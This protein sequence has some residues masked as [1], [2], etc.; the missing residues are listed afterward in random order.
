M[1]HGE[2]DASITAPRRPARSANCTMSADARGDPIGYVFYFVNSVVDSYCIANML[3]DGEV[4]KIIA[5]KCGLLGS[6]A[7]F[8]ESAF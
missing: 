4:S 2:I 3:H 7:N 8:I 6:S 5:N 1:C